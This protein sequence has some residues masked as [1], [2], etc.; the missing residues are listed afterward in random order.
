MYKIGDKVWVLCQGNAGPR[1]S[2]QPGI[3]LSKY[4]L[5]RHPDFISYMGYD[6]EINESSDEDG[7]PWHAVI[8]QLRPR[9]DPDELD[10]LEDEICNP[11][12]ITSWDKCMWNPQTDTV[13]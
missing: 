7:I 12:E 4:Y 2:W 1:G 13:K 9:D 5:A 10:S 6:V 8:E 3:I 11:N